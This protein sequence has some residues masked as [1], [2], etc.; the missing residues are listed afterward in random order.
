MK[1]INQYTNN[2]LRR[3]KRIRTRISGTDTTPRLS[4]FR[5][6]RYIYAQLIS[7]ESGR[8]IAYAHDTEVK[9]DG[10]KTPVERAKAVG[11]ALAIKAK[12]HKVT[13]VIFD[14]NGYRYHGRV[15]ALAEGA[16]EQG[17]QF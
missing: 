16:R 3:K 7:D 13:T 11:E 17:L 15:K 4:V 5:S 9:T 12:E 8:V 14:R 6:N 2:R 1:Q 10:K